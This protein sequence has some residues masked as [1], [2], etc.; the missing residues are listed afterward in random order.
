M[1]ASW[2]VGPEF[3]PKKS[4]TTHVKKKI[5]N[6]VESVLLET[7]G[8]E[9]KPNMR[10]NLTVNSKFVNISYFDVWDWVNGCYRRLKVNQVEH[11]YKI[12]IANKLTVWNMISKCYLISYILQ[13]KGVEE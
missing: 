3:T 1:S 11:Q 13:E 2:W 9:K 10:L 12:K 5:P 6:L 7:C 8:W 4:M